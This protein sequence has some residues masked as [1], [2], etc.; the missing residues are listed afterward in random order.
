MIDFFHSLWVV[1]FFKFASGLFLNKVH[2]ENIKKEILV[3]A[4]NIY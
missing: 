3:I 1:H 2:F 4:A